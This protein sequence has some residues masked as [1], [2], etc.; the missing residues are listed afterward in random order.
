MR[1]TLRLTMFLFVLASLAGIPSVKAEWSHDPFV[2]NV[3]CDAAG[4]QTNQKSVSDGAGGVIVVW[5]DDRTGAPLVYAQRIDRNGDPQ[6]AENGIRVCTFDSEQ[7]DPDIVADT[8]GGCFVVWVDTFN[9]D[10]DLFAQRLNHDGTLIWNPQ[11]ATV[12]SAATAQQGFRITSGAENGLYV[13]W[14]DTRTGD[15]NI[16]AQKLD[17]LGVRQWTAQDA[18]VCTASGIQ[19]LPDI[20]PDHVGGAIL[21]WESIGASVDIFAQRID[22]NGDPLWLLD[23][24][25][26]SGTS[27]GDHRKPTIESDGV[28][29]AFIAWS[30]EY[31]GITHFQVQR[32]AM[33]SGTSLW[34][35]VRPS[36]TNHE[37]VH[38][39]LLADD[40]H[41]VFVGWCDSLDGD[42]RIVMQR[43]HVDG[44][45][46]WPAGGVVVTPEVTVN[47][48]YRPHLSADGRDG[49]A[50]CWE[51][52]RTGEYCCAIYAQRFNRFGQRLWGNTG[53]VISAY[54]LQFFVYPQIHVNDEFNFIITFWDYRNT[55]QDIFA[56]MLDETGHLGNPAPVIIAATDFP[57]DQGGQVIV[58]WTASYL[59][60]W[61]WLAVE[62]Y[63]I[64]AR[65]MDAD[66]ETIVNTG[67]PIIDEA[68]TTRLGL[69]EERITHLYRSGWVYVDELPAM[70]LPEYSC[71]AFTFGDSTEAGIP[72]ADYMVAA[73]GVDPS[74]DWFSF[75]LSGY[76]VDNIAPGAPVALSGESA[77]ETEVNLTW[78]AS[79]SHD[80]DLAQYRIYRGI[81]GGFIMDEAHIVGSTA[82]LEFLDQSGTG[83]WFYR[84]SALDDNGNE[85]EGSNEVEVVV[86]V[87]AVDEM[88]PNR[89]L[90]Y[91]AFPNPM[92]GRTTITFDLAQPAG[93]TLSVWSVDGRL[94]A[95]L[96]NGPYPAGRHMVNWQ[97]RDDLNHLAPQ[98]V[99]F[100][101][102]R[103]GNY[104]AGERLLLMR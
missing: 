80:E 67:F 77:N 59:D 33:A 90:L 71:V 83:V 5:E 34:G 7:T 91:N 87:S 1:F 86:G 15:E 57:N 96:A 66:I 54:N 28:D 3:V 72:Y 26:V 16:Y 14:Y 23:G 38:Y 8:D 49:V 81:A 60:S 55:D 104:S 101:R 30:R 65:A 25:N 79:G 46:L 41:G 76:S 85:G 62:N 73:H 53:A 50:V 36:G 69:S 48:Q 2:N 64:W 20:A 74:H 68:I 13:G 21:T 18:P 78:A 93:I 88:A 29:G 4:H 31:N 40:N 63:S 10:I 32:I 103:A 58:N 75:P 6:W 47:S 37:T 98:G 100:T 19:S 61:D 99:Y 24:V 92:V 97:G 94:V 70:R 84:V 89:T 22:I 42:D 95:T 43:L 39:T 45:S 51:V 102:F 17:A 12:C 27:F 9:S 44:T 11:G 82:D 56:Q 52:F 35:H